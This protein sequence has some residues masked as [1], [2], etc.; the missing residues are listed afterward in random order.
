MNVTIRT[1]EAGVSPFTG[2]TGNLGVIVPDLSNPFFAGVVRG[3]QARAR[4]ADYAVFL[5]DSDEQGGEEMELVEAM[6]AQVDGLILCS[7]RQSR[8]QLD[9]V[10]GVAPLVFVNRVVPGRPAVILDAAGGMRQAIDHLAG[11]GHRRVAYLGGPAVSWSDQ[12]RRRGL[13]HAAHHGI[14]I[15]ELGPHGPTFEDGS[16]GADLALDSRVTAIVAYNDLMA[17]GV[18][19][20]LADRGVEVPGEM[21]VVGFDDIAMAA[22]VT[23]ALTTVAMPAER[24]GRAAVDLFLDRLSGASED[25]RRDLQTTLTIRASTTS[26][27]PPPPHPHQTP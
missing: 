12:D 1:R 15:V 2:R 3:V 4:A 19:S 10:L 13:R 8:A 17:L 20:R 5:A 14:E 22:M 27:P 7:S 9:R 6:A 26:V 21:S 11:L 24:A 18:L 23:P 16:H 25:L